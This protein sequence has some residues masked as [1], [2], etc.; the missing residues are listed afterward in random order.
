MTTDEL[1][2][3]AASIARSLREASSAPADVRKRFV[4]FRAMLFGRGVFDPVLARFDSATVAR[5][6]SEEIAAELDAL[7][8]SL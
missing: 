1:K 2:T 8:M 6:S 3:E 7:A 4:A 5:A